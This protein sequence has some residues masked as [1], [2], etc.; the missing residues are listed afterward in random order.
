MLT[1]FF[2]I[3]DDKKR[4]P[5]LDTPTRIHKLG[6]GKNVASCFLR[7]TIQTDLSNMSGGE[8]GERKKRK[9]SE[10]FLRSCISSHLLVLHAYQGRVS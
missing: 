7:D 6:L 3:L 5:I 8:R 1:L 2:R 9:A 4:S 10:L